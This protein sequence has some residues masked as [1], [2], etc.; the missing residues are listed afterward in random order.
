MATHSSIL[1]WET[2]QTGAAGGLQS[3]GSQRVGHNQSSLART[4]ADGMFWRDIINAAVTD[5]TISPSPG[6]P[7]SPHGGPEEGEG[8]TERGFATSSPSSTA[9]DHRLCQ[10]WLGDMG[11]GCRGSLQAAVSRQ[12]VRHCPDAAAFLPAV[13]AG[14][15]EKPLAPGQALRLCLVEAETQ[16]PRRFCSQARGPSWLL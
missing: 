8:C 7:T 11:W 6:A 4:H 2:P 9:L 12:R 10:P 14:A 3:I 13:G 15:M 1:A 5:P 16:S